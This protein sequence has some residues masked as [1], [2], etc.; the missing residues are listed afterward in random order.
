MSIHDLYWLPS[1]GVVAYEWRWLY[2]YR[3]TLKT[4]RF[5]LGV[6]LF[7]LLLATGA[8]LTLLVTVVSKWIVGSFAESPVPG[9]GGP[10][11]FLGLLAVLVSIVAADR[12]RVLSLIGGLLSM[13]AWVAYLWDIRSGVPLF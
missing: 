10:G 11:L 6:G 4:I 3:E 1:A 9:L 7:A 12:F 5:R 2:R 8:S 13:V